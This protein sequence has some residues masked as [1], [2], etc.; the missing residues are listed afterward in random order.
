MKR[1]CN[2]FFFFLLMTGYI[3]K[4]NLRVQKIMRNVVIL[5]WDKTPS[6]DPRQVLTYIINYRLV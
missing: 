4:L 3:T 2:T 1:N 5:E 6:A